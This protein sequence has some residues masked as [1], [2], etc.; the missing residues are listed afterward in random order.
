[1]RLLG[2]GFLFWAAGT[3][4][5][6]VAGHHLFD[7]R[8][9][10]LTVTVYAVSFAVMALFVRLLLARLRVA[11]RAAA[12]AMLVL[13]TLLLDPFSCLYAAVLFPNLDAA[14]IPAFG[15][16]ML[17]CCGGGLAGAVWPNA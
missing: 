12:A 7:I 6:R 15:G 1:M 14:A 11:D 3:A 8:R 9:P 16:C 5:V 10:L 13:P 17:I 4:V 2:L